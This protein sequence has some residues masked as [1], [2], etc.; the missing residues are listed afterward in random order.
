[1]EATEYVSP[2]G[3][4]QT[5]DTPVVAVRLRARGWRP[6][7][8]LDKAAEYDA[9]AA[10]RLALVQERAEQ[11]EDRRQQREDEASRRTLADSQPAVTPE[12]DP[13]SVPAPPPEPEP[14]PPVIE[15]PPETPR[16]ER[17][18]RRRTGA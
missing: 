2:D 5:V 7:P 9:A 13:A 16:A 12:P 14:E 10:E 11:R 8:E 17:K 18:P 15:S 3:V 1:M 4:T 6:R